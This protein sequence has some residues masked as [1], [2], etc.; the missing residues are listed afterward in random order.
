MRNLRDNE[1][2]NSR[3]SARDI[4]WVVFVA[5]LAWL[6]VMTAID[7][8]AE[9][10]AQRLAISAFD[11]RMPK[12]A[13]EAPYNPATRERLF[14]QA[15]GSVAVLG[16]VVYALRRRRRP[17]EPRIGRNA[18][19]RPAAATRWAK[20]TKRPR[21]TSGVVAAERLAAIVWTDHAARQEKEVA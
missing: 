21:R 9:Y 18:A 17:S 13:G 16:F 1:I 19:A 10:R 12:P 5:V 6:G 3:P 4:G 15:V 8:A 7:G 11:A 2:K 20:G 14:G